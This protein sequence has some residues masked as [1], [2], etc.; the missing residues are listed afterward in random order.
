M[1]VKT[2]RYDALDGIRVIAMLGVLVMHVLANVSYREEL[3]GLYAYIM[4]FGR[5]TSLFMVVSAFSVSCGYFEK[6][7]SKGWEEIDRF[8]KKRYSKIFPFFA[9]ITILDVILEF[10]KGSV[11]EGFANLTLVF[12]LIPHESITVI[13]VG[14]TLGVIFLFYL[15][16]PFF[17]FLMSSKFR[18]YLAYIISLIYAFVV[19]EYFD[20]GKVDFLYCSCYF[21]GGCFLYLHREAIQSKCNSI[22][23]GISI[24]VFIT[25]Y[26]LCVFR[27]AS[28]VNAVQ[29]ILFML[30]VMFAIKISRSN[31]ILSSEVMKFLSSISLEIYLCHMIIYR[32]LEKAN[33]L[34]VS[35]NALISYVISCALTF[36][37][38]VVFSV[39]FK[40]IYKAVHTR[41][42]NAE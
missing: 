39:A 6:I 8:Y 3:S 4:Y 34:K 21:L 11:F 14:W 29:Y 16:Y 25:V 13:G 12:G 37:G 17:V 40:R 33:L 32:I 31:T 19:N 28:G 15:L 20:L 41:I 1:E 5:F 24:I 30:I 35:D 27:Y 7:Q 42:V 26:Y 23:L 9:F 22:V 38:A 2:K 18:F 10:S 36:A